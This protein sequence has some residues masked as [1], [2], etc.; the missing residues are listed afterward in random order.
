MK[1]EDKKI[2]NEIWEDVSAIFLKIVLDSDGEEE[3]EFII[4]KTIKLT[5]KEYTKKIRDEIDKILRIKSEDR[6]KGDLWIKYSHIRKLDIFI[7]RLSESE[8]EVQD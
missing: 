7:K 3:L 8:K 4:D 1:K 6:G 5:K 2:F